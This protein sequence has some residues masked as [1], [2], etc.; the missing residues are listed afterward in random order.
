M[1]ASLSMNTGRAPTYRTT[2]ADATKVSVGTRTSSPGPT[3]SRMSAR[4]SAAVPLDSGGRA[5]HAQ[6]LGEFPFER[7]DV[8]TERRDPVGIERIEEQGALG[9]ADVGRRQEQAVHRATVPC[10]S[11]RVVVT[12]GAGFIGGNLCRALAEAGHD[13]VAL[14]NLSTGTK[15]NLRGIDAE[16]IEGTIL[17]P[18]ALDTALHGADAVVHLAALPSVPRSIADPVATHVANATGTLEVLEAARRGRSAPG[19]PTGPTWWWR[20]RRRSTAPTPRS[21]STRASPPSP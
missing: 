2:L 7:V 19:R 6:H 8:G 10:T 12:G 4:W 3:P 15:E 13:V 17:D 9:L 21:R 1:A 14:D 11:M 18:E 5:G 16:L 20:R